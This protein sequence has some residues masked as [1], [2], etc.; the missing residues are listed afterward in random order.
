MNNTDKFVATFGMTVPGDEDGLVSVVSHAVREGFAIVLCKPGDKIP[1]CILTERDKKT[2]DGQAQEASRLLGDDNWAKRK[3]GC[4]IEHALTVDSLGGD[5][6]KVRTKVGALIKRVGKRYDGMLNVGV[7]LGLSRMMVVDMDTADQVRGFKTAWAKQATRRTHDV[8]SMTVKS[9]GFKNQACEWVHKDGGHYWFKIPDDVELPAGQEAIS[10]VSG[11]VILWGN[12]QVLVPPSVRKEG[13]YQIIGGS[14]QAEDWLIAKVLHE[15]KARIE[16]VQ[17]KGELPDGTGDIDSW[18]AS[19]PWNEFLVPDGWTDTGIPDRCS[20]PIFTAPG[21]HASPKSATAHDAG[22]A[23]YDTSPGHAPIHIWTD[24]PPE[25]LAHAIHQS[26]T[27]SKTFTKLD[28]LVW[29]DYGGNRKDALIGLGFNHAAAS[30]DD[31]DSWTA[32]DDVETFSPPALGSPQEADAFAAPP[33]ATAGAEDGDDAGEGQSGAG[34]GEESAPSAASPAEEDED[35]WKPIYLWEISDD[36]SDK[37][38]LMPRG[39]CRDD[40]PN[41]GT[42]L[43]YPGLL[44]AFIGENESGKSWLLQ[45]EAVRLAKT[46]QLVLWLD[47]ENAAKQ[48]LKRFRAL[49]ATNEDLR[50]IDYRNPTTSAKNSKWYHGL[51]TMKYT[52]IVFDGTTDALNIFDKKA[53]DDDEVAQF[54]RLVLR[55]MARQTGAA[56]ALIDHQVKDQGSR[57]RYATGAGYKSNG[58]DGAIYVISVIE[59]VGRGLIGKVRVQVGKDKPGYVRGKSLGFDSNRLSEIAVFTIDASDPLH[60]VT[61][62]DPPPDPAVAAVP[63]EDLA[64]ERNSE[65]ELKILRALWVVE[66]YGF[67]SQNLLYQALGKGTSKPGV[68][69]SLQTLEKNGEVMIAEPDG[70]KPRLHKITNAGINR[71]DLLR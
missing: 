42:C 59:K 54:Y 13:A 1:I 30:V 33:P 8:P 14:Y 38:T 45:R 58:I 6:A 65:L 39:D 32:P 7:H 2:A 51:F 20:C 50:F 19:I 55:K 48:A 9:P 61:Y 35:S 70:T 63:P 46:G 37:P 60:L 64:P 18:A 40:D 28:Y 31:L 52:L 47:F 43:L 23:K 69:L 49:G 27:G 11:Y 36:D 57:G 34:E 66:P 10:D 4:G 25:F 62:L 44:H 24:N 21:S 41:V 15:A 29:R 22:C 68:L 56:L 16:R 5:P 67:A 3:H 17:K 26:D 12:H 71:L 53:K